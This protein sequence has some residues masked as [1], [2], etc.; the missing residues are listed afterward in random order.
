M[1]VN[2]D[3]AE[4]LGISSHP[5][6]KVKV[7]GITGA[8]DDGFKCEVAVRLPSS[9]EFIADA[10][11]VP[12]LPFACLLGQRGFF[13]SFNVRFEKEKQKFYLQPTA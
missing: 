7:G 2:S 3:I 4:A 8:R 6:K 12:G 1:M 10:T 13:D 5:L 11:F 9:D